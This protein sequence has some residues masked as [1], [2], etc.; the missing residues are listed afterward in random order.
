MKIIYFLESTCLCG[1]VK[2]ILRQAEALA[3]MGH[4][5]KVI[6]KDPFPEW[7]GGEICFVR[8]NPFTAGL[9][10]EFDIAIATTPD[11][12]LFHFRYLESKRIYH[13]IQGYEGDYQECLSIKNKIEGAYNLPIAKLTVSGRLAS[14]LNKL[15][16]GQYFPIGQGLESDYFFAPSGP[17]RCNNPEK[18]FLV[19][20][21]CISIK[22]LEI[23]LKAFSM[24]R[25]I[26]P[27][28][29]LIR[30]SPVDT[31]KEEEKLAGPI[32]EYH[33]YLKPEEVGE[34]FRQGNALLISPSGPG[35]GFG[36][37]ALE[38]MAC[39][40]PT[41]L[42]KI[43]SYQSFAT[44]VDYARFVEPEN[45]YSMAHGLTDLLTDHRERLRL[46][47]RGR[48]VAY[49]Y[50]FEKVAQKMEKIFRNVRSGSV[51]TRIDN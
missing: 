9:G 46:I 29:R 2:V 25:K 44:P 5:V 31:Q 38:A 13:L 30:I 18:I 8:Q 10:E 39:G 47:S 4:Q 37:P 32:S 15:F 3:K 1:G 20:A 23:G 26:R 21:F 34:I 51:S 41:V 43:P 11:L 6:S 19:G 24:V 7:F 12:A 22:R 49:L 50:R 33:V 16:P 42:T 28:L 40:I 14:R 48:E 17:I 36:L 45:V 27:E 35:E